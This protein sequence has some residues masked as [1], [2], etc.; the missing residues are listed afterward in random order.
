MDLELRPVTDEEFPAFSRTIEAAFGTLA[1]DNDIEL[2]R[3]VT[4]FDRTI[5]G[6]DRGQIVSTAGAFTFELTLPGLATIPV[7][8]VTAVSVAPTHRRQGILRKMMTHQLDDVVARG[9]PVAILTASES[10][11]Y[12]RFGYG[13]A[14]FQAYYDID[15]N[16][17]AFR[18]DLSSTGRVQLVD[19]ATAA[20][21]IPDVA[22]RSR[23]AQPGDHSET[24][25][26]VVARAGGST[27]HTNRPAAS[28]RALRGTASRAPG[29]TGTLSGRSA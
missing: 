17:S 2:W 29:S 13:L 19:A 21:V 11:I 27:R 18:T 6:F 3:L 4:E 9:E 15:K 20:K 28:S 8:G 12:G 22:D 10:I 23:R 5:G 1:T 26:G 16:R 25:G 7:A 24:D 14:T